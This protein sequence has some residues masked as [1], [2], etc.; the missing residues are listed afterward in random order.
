MAVKQNCKSGTSSSS[1]LSVK[2]LAAQRSGGCEPSSLE[3]TA[4]HINDR[5][6]PRCRLDAKG[7]CFGKVNVRGNGFQKVSRCD[8]HLACCA[9]IQLGYPPR[10]GV[11][12]V[13]WGKIREV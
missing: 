7:K 9:H 6:V 8:R 12:G 1:S 13:F 4:G 10:H 5:C 2:S 3:R 11:R